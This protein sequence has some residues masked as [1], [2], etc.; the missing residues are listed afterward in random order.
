MVKRV[1]RN[2]RNPKFDAAI[3]EL[4]DKALLLAMTKVAATIREQQ[5]RGL[6]LLGEVDERKLYLREGYESLWAYCT[7]ALKLSESGASR[8]TRAM[9]A[10]RRDP[11]LLMKLAVGKISLCVVA[12]LADQPVLMAVAE[13]KSIR[14]AKEM[15]AVALFAE[16]G[17]VAKATA[18]PIREKIKIK[19]PDRVAITIEVDERVRAKIERA[20]EVLNAASLSSVVE[21]AL[22]LLLDKVDPILRASRR[23]ARSAKS[24][25]VAEAAKPAKAPKPART[26]AALSRRTRDAV[27]ARDGGRCTFSTPDGQRCNSRRFLEVD[28]IQPRSCGGTDDP[29]NLRTLCSSHHGMFTAATFG[30]FRRRSPAATRC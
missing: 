3:K 14:E 27:I 4:D 26:R 1:E 5:V 18:A 24:D 28:H 16:T 23:A 25:K 21:K 12:T 8:W 13:G 9:R 19:S 2:R 20:K 15:L 10:V 6:Q 7:Q 11:S 17:D 22:D 29:L 30:D